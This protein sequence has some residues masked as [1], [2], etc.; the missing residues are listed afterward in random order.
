M[1]SPPATSQVKVCVQRALPG[2]LDCYE[3]PEDRMFECWAKALA[4]QAC[5][6]CVRIVGEEESR[7]LNRK[8][9]G[10]SYAA[11]VLSFPFASHLRFFPNYLG[12]LVL[13][14][15]VL[16]KEASSQGI[17]LESYWARLFVHGLLHLQGY[18][19]QSEESAEVMAKM[20]RKALAC[21]G[22]EQSLLAGNSS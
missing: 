11:N 19:H 10:C 15:P 14:A 21:L 13:S 17:P 1:K 18:D 16:A 20:E 12:D 9:R 2:K 3:I 8:Y 7:E 4:S 22:H 6:V 5:E